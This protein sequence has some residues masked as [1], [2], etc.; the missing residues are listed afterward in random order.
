M[1]MR[2]QIPPR[3]KIAFD[4]IKSTVT[5][6][7]RF[8]TAQELCDYMGWKNVESANDRLSRL[9]IRGL[10]KRND[11]TKKWELRESAQ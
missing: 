10:I 7:R 2:A 9:R 1:T 4:F 3:Q 6:G 11:E 5:V 8:P